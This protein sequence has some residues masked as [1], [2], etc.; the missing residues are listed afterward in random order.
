MSSAS[1][2][3]SPLSKTQLM[4]MSIVPSLFAVAMSL[5]GS[6]LGSALWVRDEINAINNQMAAVKDSQTKQEEIMVSIRSTLQ[7][8]LR[9]HHQLETIEGRTLSVEVDSLKRRVAVLEN[10]RRE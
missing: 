8:H 9:H 10:G 3:P 1:T 6:F 5:A 7:Q 4:L 2:A